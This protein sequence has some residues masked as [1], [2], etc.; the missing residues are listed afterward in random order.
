VQG[1]NNGG[2]FFL[3]LKQDSDTY[4][5]ISNAETG[6]AGIVRKVDQGQEVDS[7]ALQAA[8]S[9]GVNY[10]L[11]VNFSPTDCKVIAF[12]EILALGAD[13]APLKLNSFEIELFQEDGFFDNIEF[14][15]N[16]FDYYVA[17]G[18]SI[19][20]GSNDD[21]SSDGT[22]YEPIL[23][24]LITDIK[25]YSH[26]IV[27]E[28]VSGDTSTGG[29]S[30]MPT[31]LANNP[32]ARFFLVQYGSNDAGMPALSSG[33]GLQPGNSNYPG[34]FKD[35]MQNIITLIIEAG[36]VPYLAKVPYTTR[37]DRDLNAIQEYNLVIDEL[38]DSNH[39]G[40]VSPDFYCYF[41]NHPEF[42]ADGL[43]PNGLGYQAMAQI[44]RKV[45]TDQSSSGCNP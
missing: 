14:A 41:E 7:I 35:N 11:L 20:Q 23:E 6:G 4:Y 37:A 21:I 33:L 2:T 44:W 25:G 29:V 27:N 22:G 28:G 42:L 15:A 13:T 26:L 45:L 1:Y 38:V 32:Q 17:A 24:N 3:R 39:I 30:L 19:T 5:E 12:G 40:I 31:I 9:Q 36:K 8:F 10:H 34:T 43:H 16:P 18:D